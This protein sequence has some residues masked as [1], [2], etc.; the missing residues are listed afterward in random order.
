MDKLHEMFGSTA[1]F[2]LQP[3]PFNNKEINLEKFRTVFSGGGI[4]IM[5]Q[6]VEQNASISVNARINITNTS[7]V[8]SEFLIGKC[9]LITTGQ[10]WFTG[11]GAFHEPRSWEELEHMVRNTV[12]DEI[13]DEQAYSRLKLANWWRKHQVLHNEPTKILN[14]L[15]NEFQEKK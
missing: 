2:K 14:Q 8:T 7:G 12:S 1:L 9:P 3:S 5:N 13:S 6:S 10:S 11:L 4:K 15:I